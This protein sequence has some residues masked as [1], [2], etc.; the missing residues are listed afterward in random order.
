MNGIGFSLAEQVCWRGAWIF[1][2][3]L[4][5]MSSGMAGSPSPGEERV[6]QGI[7][8]AWIPEGRV[9]FGTDLPALAG[10]F[11]GLREEWV[12]DEA[13]RP[14]YNGGGFWM[15]RTEI[16]RGDWKR[17][18]G[19]EPW[20]ER[21]D[22]ARQDDNLPANWVTLDEARAFA[23]A[24]GEVEGMVFRLP[25][26]EEWEYACRAGTTTVFY[27]GDDPGPLVE[28]AWFRGNAPDGAA[29]AVAGLQPNP[30]GLFDMLGNVWEWCEGPYGPEGGR[31]SKNET[32]IV[33]GGAANQLA[34]FCRPG[35]RLGRPA[36]QPGARVGF[37]VMLAKPR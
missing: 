25:M 11:P 22:D 33:K 12:T 21:G 19:T 20:R 6:F 29:R 15:S 24:L 8:F 9:A 4:L 27:F 31:E 23:K 7:A 30:W 34:L 5:V 14:S 18:V 26:E 3:C 1:P 13:G 35:A 2:L 32:G 16:T 10:V 17:I 37:R 36:G 28:H